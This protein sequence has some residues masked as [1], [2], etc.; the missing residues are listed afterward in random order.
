MERISIPLLNGDRTMRAILPILALTLLGALLP[1]DALSCCGV[2]SIPLNGTPSYGKLHGDLFVCV[3]DKDQLVA[4]D[5][6][7]FM[8]T[9]LGSAKGRRWHDGDIAD[10]LLLLVESKRMMAI[11]LK[12]GKTVQEMTLTDGPLW[13]FGF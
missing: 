8:A 11:N 9:A 2:D 10:G 12:T 7:N 3:T 5:L 1:S 6:K 13:A 4:V